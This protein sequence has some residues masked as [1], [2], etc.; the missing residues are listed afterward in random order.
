MSDLFQQQNV[1]FKIP[2]QQALKKAGNRIF[3][4]CAPPPPAQCVHIIRTPQTNVPY[5]YNDLLF[6]DKC[7]VSVTGGT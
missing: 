2:S 1:K 3:S 6:I 5:F 4:V 7:S